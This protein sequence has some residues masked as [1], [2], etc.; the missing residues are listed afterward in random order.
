M[1]PKAK[2]DMA[3]SVSPLRF[4]RV[5]TTQPAL[6]LWTFVVV[7]LVGIA[8]IVGDPQRSEGVMVPV[9]LLQL[10][11]AS[12]G[13]EVPARRGHYD[14]LL[15]SG[16]RRIWM[17]VMHWGSSVAPGGMAW[18]SLAAVEWTASS[19]GARLLTAGTIAA[20]ALVSTLPWAITVR[21]P[22]F[23]GGIGWLLALSISTSVL[24]PGRLPASQP[25]HGVAEW[26]WSAWG[27]LIYPAGLVGHELSVHRGLIAM[28][29]LVLAVVAMAAACRWVSR[30]SVPLEAAQ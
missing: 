13:F 19:G 1:C 21:L 16:H 23:S 18:V 6:I 8:A 9:L 15:T 29:A 7:V 10:F 27:F 11:A 26:I 24:S 28:P 5:V 22:R 30:A 3:H 4:F 25:A 2:G 17:A 12:S 14:L 20:M